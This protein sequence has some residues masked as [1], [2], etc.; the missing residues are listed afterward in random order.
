[1]TELSRPLKKKGTQTMPVLFVSR[2]FPELFVATDGVIIWRSGC[3]AMVSL[4]LC[5]TMQDGERGGGREGG[6]EREREGGGEGMGFKRVL[7]F[8]FLNSLCDEL[9]VVAVVAVCA[10]V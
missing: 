4:L 9:Q 7:W 3:S 8:H 1:M 5:R 10:A 6:R 2:S